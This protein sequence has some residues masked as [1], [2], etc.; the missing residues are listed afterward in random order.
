MSDITFIVLGGRV[1]RFSYLL[2]YLS[3]LKRNFKNKKIKVFLTMNPAEIK[4]CSKI[5]KEH[6]KSNVLIDLDVEYLIDVHALDTFD[7][8]LNSKKYLSKENHIVTSSGHM[9]RSKIIAK[10]LFPNKNFSG[11]RVDDNYRRENFKDFMIARGEVLYYKL[12]GKP[13]NSKSKRKR[14][15]KRIQQLKDFNS[16]NLSFPKYTVLNLGFN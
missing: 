15:E 2:D 11:L 3:M 13:K 4:R 10:S 12:F 14:K 6:P 16:D 7:N 1:D 9:K 5:Y 8:I